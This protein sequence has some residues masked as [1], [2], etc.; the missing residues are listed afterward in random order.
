[1]KTV[2]IISLK[3]YTSI[4][5]YIHPMQLEPVVEPWSPIISASKRFYSARS[6]SRR[7]TG[8]VWQYLILHLPLIK[9]GSPHWSNVSELSV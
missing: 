6:A 1:M 7:D 3:S 9:P 4:N 8:E 2:S 5:P